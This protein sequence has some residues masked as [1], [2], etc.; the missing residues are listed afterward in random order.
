MTRVGAGV[1]VARLVVAVVLVLVSETVLVLVAVEKAVDVADTE[2]CCLSASVH[3]HPLI[4]PGCRA[5]GLTQLERQLPTRLRP[6]G[7]CRP[8]SCRTEWLGSGCR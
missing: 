4:V 3:G 8:K 6:W 5:Y 2:L 7:R 1:G